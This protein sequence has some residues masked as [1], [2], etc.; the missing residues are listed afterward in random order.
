MTVVVQIKTRRVLNHLKIEFESR[1]RHG[2]N[3]SGSNL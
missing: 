2:L 3:I 1:S